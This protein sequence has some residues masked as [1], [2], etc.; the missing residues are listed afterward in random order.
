VPFFEDAKPAPKEKKE[1][2]YEVTTVDG[3]EWP[4]EAGCT[5]EAVP[6]GSE[7]HYVVKDS[8]GRIDAMYPFISVRCIQLY[9]NEEDE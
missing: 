4:H 2:Y 3:E 1:A 7:A 8:K 6:V 9:D 5:I